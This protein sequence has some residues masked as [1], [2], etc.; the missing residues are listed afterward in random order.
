[1]RFDVLTAL[2]LDCQI[3]SGEQLPTF[4]RHYLTQRQCKVCL[5]SAVAT[6]GSLAADSSLQPWATLPYGGLDHSGGTD[7]S[8][9]VLNAQNFQT[10]CS[11]PWASFVPTLNKVWQE[12]TPLNSSVGLSFL[13]ANLHHNKASHT[14]TMRKFKGK[15]TVL[16]VHV[17]KANGQAEVWLHS[18]LTSATGGC[19]WSAS[20][21]S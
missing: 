7:A 5:P 15:V 19:E 10:F 16:P 17:M 13:Q 2:L 6:N 8:A 1:V 3:L 21:P 18:I 14:H 11:K 12:E 4:Q 9:R 20:C